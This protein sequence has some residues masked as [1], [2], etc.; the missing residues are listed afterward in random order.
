MGRAQAPVG[1]GASACQPLSGLGLKPGERRQRHILMKGHPGGEAHGFGTRVSGLRIAILAPLALIAT[2]CAPP[3]IPSSGREEPGEQPGAVQ[4]V[5]HWTT[6]THAGDRGVSTHPV[7]DVQEAPA[8]CLAYF[9]GRA[10]NADTCVVSTQPFEW[11]GQT[12]PWTVEATWAA[13]SDWD[14]ETVDRL[15]IHAFDGDNQPL[16]FWDGRMDENAGHVTE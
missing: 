10:R 14:D 3:E 13:L 5:G 7:G 8:T 4:L 9:D 15:A 12:Y 16:A 11:A 2:A 6:A 1:P